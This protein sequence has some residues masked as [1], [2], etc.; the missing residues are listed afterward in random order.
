MSLL[1]GPGQGGVL[2]LSLDTTISRVRSIQLPDWSTEPVDFTGLSDLEWFQFIAATL[3]NGGLLVAECYFNTEIARPSVRVV[4]QATYTFPIQTAGNGTAGVLVGSGF[5]TNVG[6]PNAAVGEPMME[7][8]SFQFDGVGTKPSY[9][10]EV[11]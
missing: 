6:F 4:Q 8:I 1:G 9:T 11:A 2:A 10:T 5:V 3:K 7:T